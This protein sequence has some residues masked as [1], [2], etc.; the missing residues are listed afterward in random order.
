MYQPVGRGPPLLVYGDIISCTKTF[1]MEEIVP[2][3]FSDG[4]IAK[5]RGNSERGSRT[6]CRSRGRYSP[7]ALRIDR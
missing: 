6:R 1:E 3:S 2:V 7:L 5:K 4:N